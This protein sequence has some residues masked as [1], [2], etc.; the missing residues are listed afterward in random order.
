MHQQ[1]STTKNWLASLQ[2]RIEASGKAAAERREAVTQHAPGTKGPK[3][4]Y[5][6]ASVEADTAA[7]VRPQK[8]PAA[9]TM[10]ALSAG[11]PFTSYPLRSEQGSDG[12]G[13]DA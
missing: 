5:E 4:E 10:R 3:R 13:D 2:E 11:M 6:D 9:N 1:R 8:L 12:G 7:M